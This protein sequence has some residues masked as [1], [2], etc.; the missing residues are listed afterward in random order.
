MLVSHNAP[1]MQPCRNCPLP[2][3]PGCSVTPWT[4]EEHGWGQSSA[5]TGCVS[6][7]PEG[8]RSQPCG[9]LICTE[10]FPHSVSCV[11]PPAMGTE[12]LVSTGERHLALPQGEPHKRVGDLASRSG[13]WGFVPLCTSGRALTP[14]DPLCFR[15]LCQLSVAPRT[16]ADIDISKLPRSHRF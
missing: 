5:W 13:I 10:P 7:W 11:S 8:P 14:T 1:R 6:S 15:S 9:A 2:F 4:V 16:G 12:A 3:F